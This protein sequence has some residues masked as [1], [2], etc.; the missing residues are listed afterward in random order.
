MVNKVEYYDGPVKISLKMHSTVAV[1]RQTAAAMQRTDS[2]CRDRATP[3]CS[4]RVVRI[5]AIFR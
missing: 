1:A 5:K 4:S 3:S 2:A